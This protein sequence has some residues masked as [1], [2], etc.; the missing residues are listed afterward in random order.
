MSN[1][2]NVFD[3]KGVPGGL[4]LKN[5]RG[6]NNLTLRKGSRNPWWAEG[7][8]RWLPS[9]KRK[10]LHLKRRADKVTPAPIPALG[11]WEVLAQA[12]PRR[13]GVTLDAK[14]MFWY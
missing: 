5:A 10:P 4:W 7:K 12:S 14:W 9:F 13:Q 2:S 6:G 8:G 1:K 3:S 11:L